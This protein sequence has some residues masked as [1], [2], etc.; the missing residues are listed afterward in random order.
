MI[1]N[2]KRLHPDAVIPVAAHGA[3]Q[4]AGFDLHCVENVE[5]NIGVPTLVRTGLAIA[6]PEYFQAEVRPRSGLA[7]KYGLQVVNSP[8]TIDPSYRG[9][10][11]V[12]L[13]WNGW[14][15][16]FQTPFK[17]DTLGLKKGDRV[18]QLVCSRY[19]PVQFHEVYEDLGN[20]P[21]Q[22]GGFGS[23]GV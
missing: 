11:G 1:I 22:G 12:I 18:A 9:E 19:E 21:R 20:T 23:T 5:L 7:L 14:A 3:H 8:G 15:N 17:T 13:L 4:D 2:I 10:I 16:G 6:L